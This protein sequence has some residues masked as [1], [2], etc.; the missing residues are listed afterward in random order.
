MHPNPEPVSLT[1]DHWI[2]ISRLRSKDS[3]SNLERWLQIGWLGFEGPRP[4]AEVTG[5]GRPAAAHG[6][7]SPDLAYLC[8][9]GSDLDDI[10]PG[11]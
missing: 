3:Q 9:P 7:N 8:R 1:Q 11:G 5:E 2:L 10:K 6:Y 4:A